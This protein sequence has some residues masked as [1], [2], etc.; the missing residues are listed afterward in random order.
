MKEGACGVRA[1]AL[2]QSLTSVRGEVCARPL[3]GEEFNGGIT[4]V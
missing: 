1:G 3:G 2:G 4:V